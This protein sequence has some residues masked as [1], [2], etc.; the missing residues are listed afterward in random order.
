VDERL[1]QLF[2]RLIAGGLS[3]VAGAE[4]SVTLPVSSRLLNELI[5]A[6][7]P[8]SSPIRDLEVTP[9]DG[10]RFL[11]RG[12]IGSSLLPLL[13]LHVA[14]ER[15]AEFPAFAVLVLRVE[16]TGL[17][18]LASHVSRLIS[19]PAWIR[20][21][22]DRIHVDLRVLAD[23]YGV[24]HYVSYVDDLQVKTVAGTLLLSLRARVR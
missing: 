2:D 8:T 12:R 5:S 13:K 22:R 20:M 15:Q 9:L 11:V 24:R 14:I 18:V 17:M 23:Q 21:E 3:D 10:D 4:A 1:A 7:L 6:A 16:S 19:L